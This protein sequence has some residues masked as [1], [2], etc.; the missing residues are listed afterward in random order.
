LNLR[1]VTIVKSQLCVIISVTSLR[2]GFNAAQRFSLVLTLP[3][4]EKLLPNSSVL[5]SQKSY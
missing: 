2:N 4:P 1:A 3:Q 5:Y